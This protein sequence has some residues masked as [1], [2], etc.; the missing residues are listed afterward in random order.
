[1]RGLGRNSVAG[2]RDTTGGGGDLA[3]IAEQSGSGASGTLTFASIPATYKN[4]LLAIMG[5][6]S[7]GQPAREVRL[8]FNADTGGNYQGTYTLVAGTTSSTGFFDT[9]Y[10]FLGQV[11]AATATANF[12]GA[13]HVLIP[14]YAATVFYKTLQVSAGWAT[15]TGNNAN[16]QEGFGVWRD[17]AAITQIDLILQSGNWITGSKA[18]LYGIN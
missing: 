10:S 14:D 6:S 4:L 16:S 12:P 1:M 13:L 15:G 2:F 17:T 9:T 3:L 8:Q 5:R 11:A 7:D 18:Q